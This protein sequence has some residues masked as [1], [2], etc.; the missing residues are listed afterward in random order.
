MDSP[1]FLQFI[2]NPLAKNG[3][4]PPVIDSYRRLSHS[5]LHFLVNFPQ[6]FHVDITPGLVTPGPRSTEVSESSGRWGR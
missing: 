1:S 2:D 6:I 3:E 4:N 5:N